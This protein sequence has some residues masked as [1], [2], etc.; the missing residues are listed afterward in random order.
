ME[1][2][3][4]GGGDETLGQLWAASPTELCAPHSFGAKPYGEHTERP[5]PLL[6]KVKSIRARFLICAP[7]AGCPL[8][9]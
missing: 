4:P 9:S 6:H 3:C 8:T 1:G 2:L 5:S 7:C